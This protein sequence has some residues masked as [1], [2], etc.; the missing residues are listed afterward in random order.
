MIKRLRKEME[1][2]VQRSQRREE[3]RAGAKM[4]SSKNKREAARKQRQEQRQIRQVLQQEQNRAQ[5]LDHVE[6]TS[7]LE[8][9]ACLPTKKHTVPPQKGLHKSVRRILMAAPYSAG[10]RSKG[11]KSTKEQKQAGR[12]KKDT[13]RTATESL[14]L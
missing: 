11:E 13:S 3:K 4:K 1:R 10:K 9:K 8:E 2:K 6:A 12:E 5:Q 7:T 14:F